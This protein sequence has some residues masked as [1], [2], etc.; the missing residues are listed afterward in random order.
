MI[1]PI[2]RADDADTAEQARS[3]DD[4]IDESSV[5]LG[6]FGDNVEA[7]AGDVLEQQLAVSGDEDE[8]PPVSRPRV[9]T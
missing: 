2:P 9:A 8:R 1:D 6:E 5:L 7:D 3:V 4:G